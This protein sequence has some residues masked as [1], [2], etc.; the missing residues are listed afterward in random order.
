MHN[1]LNAK[2]KYFSILKFGVINIDTKVD[3]WVIINDMKFF[4]IKPQNIRVSLLKYGGNTDK[5]FEI[6][7]IN[8]IASTKIF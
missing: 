7:N 8:S 5:V 1:K 3:S 2:N 4:N 6:D